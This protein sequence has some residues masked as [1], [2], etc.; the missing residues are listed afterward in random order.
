MGYPIGYPN[1]SKRILTYPRFV[2]YNLERYPALYPVILSYM[3]SYQDI[4]Y[5]NTYPNEISYAY[6]LQ[7]ILLVILTYPNLS[8]I[9]IVYPV[10][11]SC[12]ISCNII[13]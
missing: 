11:I 8:F 6:I 3:I 2:S 1:L 7:D 10:K 5:S 13:L 4:L 9:C 12:I